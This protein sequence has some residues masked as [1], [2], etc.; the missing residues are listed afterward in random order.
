MAGTTLES[1]KRHLEA[2]GQSKGILP[3]PVDFYRKVSEY[4]QKMR[5]LAG[6]GNSEVAVRLLSRQTDM[7]R[8]MS[9]ELLEVR[10]KK[11]FEQ[12]SLSQLLPEERYVCFA[13]AKFNRRFETFIEALSSGQPSFIEL[14]QRNETLRNVTVRFTKHVDELVGL[15]LRHYGPFEAEDLASIPAANAGVLVAAGDAVEV[16]SRNDA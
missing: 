16:F 2:E 15:D 10:A 4:S 9:K 7:I 3:L 8:G 1:L 12:N 5:R 11:A 14:A 13:R 6:S